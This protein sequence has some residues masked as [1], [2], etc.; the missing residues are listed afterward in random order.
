MYPGQQ[1]CRLL[2]CHNRILFDRAP[3]AAGP[4]LEDKEPMYCVPSRP[5]VPASCPVSGLPFSLLVLSL[6]L[7][8]GPAPAP[9]APPLP[10]K[11]RTE[12]RSERDYL[13]PLFYRD[14]ALGTV[15]NFQPAFGIGFRF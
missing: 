1:S 4:H 2:V 14:A 11:P 12:R 5:T 10:T 3:E 13:D 15:H 6:L 7:L 9:A 8:E